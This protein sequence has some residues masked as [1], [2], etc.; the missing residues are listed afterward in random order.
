MGEGADPA[1][2]GRILRGHR[3]AAGLTQEELAGHAGLSVRALSDIERGRTSRPR[4][5][6]V[7]LLADVLELDEPARTRLMSALH[8]DA[9]QV[10]PSGAVGSHVDL[11]QPAAAAP[12]RAGALLDPQASPVMSLADT[13]PADVSGA[14][15]GPAAAVRPDI[16]ARLGR[17]RRA[18]W[19]RWSAVGVAAALAGGLFWWTVLSH[20]A[21]SAPVTDGAYPAV[22]HCDYGARQLASSTVRARD[23]TFWGTVEVRYSYRCAAVWT[24]FD[25]GP[26]FANAS[27]ATVT[28]KIVRRPGGKDEVSSAVDP[29]RRQ[30][31]GLLLLHG[32]CAQGSARITE[33]G[34]A[35]AGATTSCQAPP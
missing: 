12:S 1:G 33:L 10:G 9:D 18:R 5:R 26:A 14:N 4:A 6:S 28:F 2:F 13:A 27:A 30:R 24:R 20:G 23:G 35:L 8:N 32:G 25:P 11:R 15:V 17:I 7:R 29:G 3:V 31:T 16:G 19:A 21:P 22:G 34:K